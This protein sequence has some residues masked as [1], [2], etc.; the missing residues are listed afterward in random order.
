MIGSVCDYELV[1]PVV[2]YESG[3]PWVAKA[4]ASASRLP[5]AF[6]DVAHVKITH[7]SPHPGVLYSC[8]RL[9]SRGWADSKEA[10]HFH[11]ERALT[12]VLRPGDI[13]HICRTLQGGV[14]LS[15][16]RNEE[17]LAAVGAVCSV[18]LGRNVTTRHP[19]ELI[20]EGLAL[21]R[22][23][24]RDFQWDGT[25]VEVS[26]AGERRALQR[27]RRSFAGYEVFMV[28]GARE[29]IPGTDACLAISRLTERL[30][31]AASDTAYL[32]DNGQEGQFKR[33]FVDLAWTKD[34][35]NEK[36]RHLETGR[37]SATGT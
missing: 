6:G 15:V 9:A 18:P 10:L 25:P 28:H 33:E 35:L 8:I 29:G 1:V 31:L 27:G 30:E 7:V 13:V 3:I 36:I 11:V 16:V 34:L 32:L 17:L 26:I 23:Y 20:A 37:P 24:D 5:R 12:T 21:F 14:A 22:R 2:S 4:R 19:Q